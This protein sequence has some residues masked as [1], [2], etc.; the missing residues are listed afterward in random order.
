MSIIIEIIIEET[1]VEK[2]ETIEVKILEMVL[3]NAITL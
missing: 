3:Y 2:H 1:I